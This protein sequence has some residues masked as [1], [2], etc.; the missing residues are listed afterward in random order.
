MVWSSHGQD[1]V[2]VPG[3]VLESLASAH[4]LGEGPVGPVALLSLGDLVTVC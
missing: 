4:P 3:V 2:G 1:A